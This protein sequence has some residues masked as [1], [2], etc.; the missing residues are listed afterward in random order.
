MRR[1]SEYNEER[2]RKKPGNSMKKEARKEAALSK[3]P[4][5]HS[6]NHKRDNWLKSELS[7]LSSKPKGNT[8]RPDS[9]ECGKSR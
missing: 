7:S 5:F 8:G 3:R 1:D 2:E 6:Q 9:A 4:L